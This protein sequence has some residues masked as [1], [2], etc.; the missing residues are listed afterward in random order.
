M[1][2]NH[3]LVRA[4]RAE[5]KMSRRA[6]GEAAGINPQT[7]WKIESETTSEP[8]MRVVAAIAA[9]FGVEPMTFFESPTHLGKVDADPAA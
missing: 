2:F 6:L 9:V 8:S 4:K 1:K 5:K 3:E 7:V